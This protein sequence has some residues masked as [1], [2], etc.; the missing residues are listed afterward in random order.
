MWPIGTKVLPE[1][2]R[3]SLPTIL[4]VSLR[5]SFSCSV[6]LPVSKNFPVATSWFYL[7]VHVQLDISVYAQ[8]EDPLDLPS[9]QKGPA[10]AEPPLHISPSK[11][12][13]NLNPE[14]FEDNV[15]SS[16]RRHARPALPPSR[17]QPR[18]P[19]S[20]RRPSGNTSSGNGPRQ[21]DPMG[22]GR[23][24]RLL[25]DSPSSESCFVSPLWVF[26]RSVQKV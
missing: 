3:G 16:R 24:S 6:D 4:T 14:S 15:Q 8:P 2:L 23:P 22:S 12:A 26:S 11:P 13:S 5:G 7:K 19:S 18:P 25:V 10:I 20:R 9:C 21:L 17:G 1:R